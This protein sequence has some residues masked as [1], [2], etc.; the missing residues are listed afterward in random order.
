M[1]QEI[2]R[3]RLGDT[4]VA[5]DPCQEPDLGL[6]PRIQN[7]LA[8]IFICKIEQVNMRCWGRRVKS[9]T[10]TAENANAL[11]QTSR[12]HYAGDV[13]VDSGQA[14]I[15]PEEYFK[16]YCKDDDYDA[17]PHSWYRKICNQTLEKDWGEIDEQCVVSS[18]GT[19]D[20]A[21]PVFVKWDKET[22]KITQ[23]KI[24]FL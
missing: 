15:F 21:Y 5:I 8:G 17:E 18:S 13:Y 11:N 2:A 10:A 23:I 3:I 22:E 20:G 14:G 4:V 16:K 24:Q 12:W 7:V 9:L 1:E 19:G 6:G